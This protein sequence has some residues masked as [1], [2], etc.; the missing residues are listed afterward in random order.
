MERCDSDVSEVV[1][2]LWLLVRTPQELSTVLN[3]IAEI[4]QPL[5]TA[6]LKFRLKARTNSL[7]PLTWSN[8]ILP[9]SQAETE[10]PFSSLETH[11][12]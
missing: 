6:P 5:W 10:L 1:H 11:N 9:R 4:G 2:L 8:Q 3:A 7:P 12:P